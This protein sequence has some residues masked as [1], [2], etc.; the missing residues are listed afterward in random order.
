MGAWI[1]TGV[2]RIYVTD[3]TVAPYMG[4]WIETITEDKRKI[5][6]EVAPYMGAWIETF[7]S[8]ISFVNLCRTLHGCVD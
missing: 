5:D 2:T 3:T 4:A 7:Y 1:E 8:E 6:R